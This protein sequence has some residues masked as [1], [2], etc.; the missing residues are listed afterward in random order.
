MDLSLLV[1]LIICVLIAAWFIRY[2]ASI[3][4]ENIEPSVTEKAKFLSSNLTV[5]YKHQIGAYSGTAAICQE[6]KS[7]VPSDCITFGI[8]YDSPEDV[9]EHLLQSA[10]G[11]IF[12]IDGKSLY[13]DNYAQQLTRLGYEKMNISKVGKTV[14][15][16]QRNRGFLSFFALLTNTYPIL[17]KYI[18]THRLETTYSMEFYTS[19][20][21]Y[22]Y[23]PL[24]NAEELRVPEYKSVER[25]EADMAKKCFDSDLSDSES[26]PEQTTDMEG[27]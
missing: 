24:E 16:I 13:S 14:Q 12:S 23:F 8:F 27:N 6:I 18:E 7:I 4:F 9:K 1:I 26:E 17:K 21:F 25:L 10:V 22:V 2:V 3:F 5:Y 19:D 20:H 15:V 11:V